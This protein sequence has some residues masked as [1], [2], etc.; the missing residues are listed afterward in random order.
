MKL[1][2]EKVN[3]KTPQIPKENITTRRNYLPGTTVRSPPIMDQLAPISIKN[4]PVPPGSQ[5]IQNVPHIQVAPIK[6]E[7]QGPHLKTGPGQDQEVLHKI[8]GKQRVNSFAKELD[9]PVPKGVD[10][11]M[12]YVTLLGNFTNDITD[13]NIRA[14]ILTMIWDRKP[15]FS[16]HLAE[17]FAL[18]DKKNSPL[19]DK[20]KGYVPSAQTAAKIPDKNVNTEQKK[21]Q[22]AV[23]KEE[24]LDLK[25]EIIDNEEK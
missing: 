14:Q 13:E 24:I 1:E 10:E 20:S 23:G 6:Q 17:L 19:P 3:P 7:L 21:K 11:N 2:E 8:S 4:D 5:T 22:I 16:Q 9:K 12:H 15:Q 25:Q 18:N